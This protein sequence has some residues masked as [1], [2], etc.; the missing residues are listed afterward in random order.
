MLISELVTL[1]SELV[2]LSS[3]L[4]HLV[5]ISEFGVFLYSVFVVEPTTQLTSHFF[6]ETFRGRSVL[7]DYRSVDLRVVVVIVD[8]TIFT[9]V[10]LI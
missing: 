4:D 7:F 8:L 5:D 2:T 6:R 10:R 9:I 1:S 3:E